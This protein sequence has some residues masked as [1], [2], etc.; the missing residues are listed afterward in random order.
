[1]NAHS[2]PPNPS[3]W[4]LQTD[5]AGWRRNVR[6]HVEPFSTSMIDTFPYTSSCGIM[7]NFHCAVGTGCDHLSLFCWMVLSPRDH[8]VMH[9]R[10]RIWRKWLC[11]SKVLNLAYGAKNR[12]RFQKRLTSKRSHAHTIPCSSP[13][14]LDASPYPKHDLHL[15]EVTVC[16]VKSFNI[17]PVAA[18]MRRV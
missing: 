9:F 6:R 12:R 15:Y 2:K 5:K 3:I 1:M 10:W 7:P 13:A 8:L 16:P 18:S 14:T 4:H 11:L 17:F